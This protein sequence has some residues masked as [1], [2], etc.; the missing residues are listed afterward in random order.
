LRKREK[1]QRKEKEKIMR[2]KKYRSL[3]KSTAIAAAVTVTFFAVMRNGGATET[4]PPDF[5]KTSTSSQS[6][7]AGQQRGLL[8][9]F[10]AVSQDINDAIAQNKLP[11][12]VVLIGHAG[13]VVFEKAYGQ[14]AC[15]D[16]D[17]K[18]GAA[19][20]GL[21]GL[22]GLTGQAERM[23]E[24]TVFDMASLTKNLVTAV[25]VMQLAEQKRIN[26]DDPVDKYLPAFTG[27][28]K[29]Q[30]TI[31]GLLTHYSGLPSGISRKSD[32]GL[33]TPNKEEGI[34]LAINTP[35]D[36]ST[37]FGSAA[38]GTKFKYS[39]INFILL[40]AIV[41]KIS[42]QRLDD[43]ARE[44]I[45]APLGMT[46]TRYLSYDRTCHYHLSVYPACLPAPPSD[47]I[48]RD[49]IANIAPTAHDMEGTPDTNPDYDHLLRGV[50]H[51]PSTRRMGGVAGH[52][53]VF[54]TAA[55]VSKFA[56]ALLDKLLYD[57]GPFPLTQQTLR[58]MTTPQQPP[59]ALANATIFKQDGSLTTG[60]ALQGLGW[61]INSAYSKP[62]GTV[63]PVN[64]S[65]GHT[66][67][68]GTSLWI[69]PSSDTYV[70]VLANSVYPRGRPTIN[71]MRAAV[72]TD[73][74]KALGL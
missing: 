57:T 37:P 29:G 65:F 52:A 10:P 25:A 23:T 62:R 1:K 39:D 27:G 13:H 40:G 71:P 58:L 45:F 54:S 7:I 35:P 50:V 5:A 56:Q 69:D 49:W 28:V 15:N 21:G 38:P 74:G 2:S 67:F 73:A 11:G 68:T 33:K 24:N 30:V 16:E 44:H 66:G 3:M 53:G 20:E 61:D 17:C 72:A 4:I 9:G 18:P 51:D 42:G 14:R 19:L 59:A 6:A 31:R 70:I 32:W 64:V 22:E 46:D 55:D 34:Q 60:V 8:D 41:E 36:S 12:A 47:P 63:F 26:I 48:P 43:Y